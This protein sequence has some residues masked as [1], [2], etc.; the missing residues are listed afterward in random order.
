M[1]RRLFSIDKIQK[2]WGLGKPLIHEGKKYRIGRMSYGTYFL[3]PAHYKGRETDP[4]PD[5][6]LWLE[7]SK[8]KEEKGFFVIDNKLF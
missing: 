3:E 4:F 8:E 6:T 2:S 1:K 7:R 5:G